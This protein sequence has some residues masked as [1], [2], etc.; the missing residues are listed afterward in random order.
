MTGKHP[1][2]KV[3]Y[4]YPDN[5][6]VDNLGSGMCDTMVNG[7]E[8]GLA[9]QTLGSNSIEPDTTTGLHS[10]SPL[11]A[12]QA[13][14]KLDAALPKPDDYLSDE[15]HAYQNRPIG[16]EPT[17]L[18]GTSQ[19]RPLVPTTDDSGLPLS[20]ANDD[21]GHP[22]C[23]HCPADPTSE[24]F[25]E[26][27]GL[28][29]CI[30]DR[31]IL[32]PSGSFGGWDDPLDSGIPAP[33]TATW[34]DEGF[35]VLGRHSESIPQLNRGREH[36]ALRKEISLQRSISLS[37]FE[38]FIECERYSEDSRS[39]GNAGDIDRLASD[40]GNLAFGVPFSGHSYWGY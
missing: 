29:T 18:F 17:P 34:D 2:A 16:L 6:L 24:N 19:T 26:R 13:G 15:S 20:L 38:S 9:S 25:A 21:N 3:T 5:Q 30:C 10:D 12:D 14:S 35:M 36:A 31:C 40:F 22:V 23:I 8:N 27:I 4:K 28:C 1:E 11:L 39:L 32:M 37:K 33:W 7:F